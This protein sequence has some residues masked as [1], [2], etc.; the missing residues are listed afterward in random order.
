LGA[1]GADR[2]NSLLIRQAQE[3]RLVKHRRKPAKPKGGDDPGSP[4]TKGTQDV[5]QSTSP[6]HQGEDTSYPP[7][8]PH[9]Q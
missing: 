1:K 4:D 7:T 2:L 5:E 9:L 6:D 3:L 8:T